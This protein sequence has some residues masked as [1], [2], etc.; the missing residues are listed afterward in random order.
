MTGT[1]RVELM[2]TDND[3]RDEDNVEDVEGMRFKT[4]KTHRLNGWI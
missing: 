1:W 3:P 4:A 2:T